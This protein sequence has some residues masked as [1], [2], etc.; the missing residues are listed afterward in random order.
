MDTEELNGEF[1]PNPWHPITDKTDLKHL[2]KLAEECGE[3][4]GAICR[5]IIQ[6]IDE[7]EPKTG[8]VNRRW[9]EDELA[10]VQAGINLLQEHLELDDARIRT[11]M[12]KK[13]VYLSRWHG[14]A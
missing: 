11:R 2:G 1:D 3:L 9:L 13:M 5:C 12:A 14:K 8:K 4:I 10:D 6:G 7:K